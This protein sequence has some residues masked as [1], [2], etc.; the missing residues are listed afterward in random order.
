[1]NKALAWMQ[2]ALKAVQTRLHFGTSRWLGYAL[3]LGGTRYSYAA[4]ASTARTNAAVMACVRWVC[5]TFP[6]APLQVQVR[7]RDGHLDAQPDHALQALF[8]QPNPYYSGLHLWLGT[9]ADYLLD[10]NAYWV[11]VRSEANRV[12]ELWWVPSMQ[13]EPRWP[14]DGSAFISHYDYTVDGEIYPLDRQD[15]VHF[16]DGF[17]PANLRKGH[18]PL[19]SLLREIAT[20]DEAANFTASILRNLGVPGVVISP[21]G[22]AGID[23]AAFEDIKEAFSARF[24]GDR[25]GEPLVMRGATKVSVL[26]FSPEQMQ[27]RELRRIPEERITAIFGVPAV[28]VGLG[29]GLDKA[30]YSNVAQAREAAYESAL[31]PLQRLFLADLQAQLVPD[32]GDG[33]TL[34]VAFDYAQVRVLQDDQNALMTRAAEGFQRGVLT[35]GEARTM[36]GQAAETVDDVFL[37]PNIVAVVPR[38]LKA[39]EP[40]P[41]P[42]VTPVEPTALPVAAGLLTSGQKADEPPV[43]ITPADVAHARAWVAGLDGVPEL[44]AALGLGT[45]GNG[46]HG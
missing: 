35:R 46:Q 13:V 22:D 12:V 34:R 24:G 7:G 6:E 29:A 10:G 38:K 33:R 28:V 15:V 31:I 14:D 2:T 23:E 18:S 26:S 43:H 1:V 32:F 19:R 25:R 21:E 27:M 44:Q 39:V 37:L 16:R 17:D 9:L 20:D 3:S 40:A 11:K 5:R 8:E 30:T 41:A 45:N 42:V 4:T 36:V